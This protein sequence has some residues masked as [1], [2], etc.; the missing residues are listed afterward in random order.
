MISFLILILLTT[1]A[2]GNHLRSTER[3]EEINSWALTSEEITFSRNNYKRNNISLLTRGNDVEFLLDGADFMAA[4]YEDIEKAKVGDFIHATFFEEDGRVMFRP[5]SSDIEESKKSTVYNT[6]SRAVKRGAKVRL[7]VNHNALQFFNAVP[8]C[9]ELNLMCGYVCCAVDGRH[10]NWIGGNLHT[11]MWI[12]KHG[13]ETVVYNGGIDVAGGRWDTQKHDNSP[14][15]RM[16]YKFFT[17]T[18]VH[19]SVLR[20][21]GPAV[22]DYERH[23][24]QSWNDPY[25]AIFPMFWLPKY[26]WVEPPFLKHEKGL[27]V[28]LLRTVGCKGS[29]QGYYQNFAPKGEVS[30]LLALYK[31]ISKAKNFLY[32]EDQF[33]NFDEPMRAVKEALPRLKAVII[34]TNNQNAPNLMAAERYYFQHKALSQL[35]EDPVQA[36]KVHVF[37]LVRD[38]DPTQYIYLHSKIFIADDEY[39]IGGSF[40]IERSGLTNDM[41]VGMGLFDPAGNFIKNARKRIWAE[42][43]MLPENDSRLDDVVEGVKEWNRQA[44]SESGRVRHYFPKNPKRTLLTDLFYQVYEVDGRC[45]QLLYILT[46]ICMS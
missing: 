26:D 41:E 4:L 44:D 10:H 6:V 33:F 36:A 43:L 30:G 28:Q 34:V 12:V 7:L 2:S 14:E 46:K 32:M 40:G 15:K 17:H 20:I 13:D 22:V 1:L 9:L 45:Y 19:D 23:F 31:M 5:N 38:T 16:N 25:P 29:S 8:F 3:P 37:S 39:M 24:H 27:Q 35:L 11:K 18:A 42:H 21:T